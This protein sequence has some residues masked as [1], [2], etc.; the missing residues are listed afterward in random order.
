[1]FCR[2]WFK[3]DVPQFYSPV[4]NLLL[5]VGQKNTWSG[6]K[7]LGELK[8][9]RGIKCMPKEDSLYKV[10]PLICYTTLLDIN[11]YLIYFIHIS[12][13]SPGTTCVQ[14]IIYT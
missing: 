9:E 2:T 8:R 7:T 4:V 11:K 6:M 12:G 1:M 14:T 13:Y 3:V 10:F 5:P